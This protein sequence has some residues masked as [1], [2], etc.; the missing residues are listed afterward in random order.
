[1]PSGRRPQRPRLVLVSVLVVS[2]GVAFALAALGTHA[3]KPAATRAAAAAP[4]ATASSAKTI[5]EA[6]HS[7]VAI[8]GASKRAP[9]RAA[10][11][12]AHARVHSRAQAHQLMSRRGLVA[13]VHKVSKP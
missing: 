13:S 11:S 9:E 8:R 5:L 10:A 6:Q 12:R 7:A 4:A 2:L 1:M 3:R